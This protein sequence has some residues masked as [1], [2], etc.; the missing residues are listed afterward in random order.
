MGGSHGEMDVD[1]RVGAGEPEP[2]TVAV[3]AGESVTEQFTYT[4]DPGFSSCSV[5]VGR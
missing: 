2:T 5:S 4:R 1:F 3:P